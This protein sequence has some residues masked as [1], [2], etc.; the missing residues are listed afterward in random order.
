M[1]CQRYFKVGKGS[2]KKFKSITGEGLNYGENQVNPN[3]PKRTQPLY[4][5]EKFFE[6]LT[7]LELKQIA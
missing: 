3:N 1:L 2:V 5:E 4:Y 7:L 6:L